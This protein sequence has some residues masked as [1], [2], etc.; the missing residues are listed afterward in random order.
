MNTMFRLN[1]YK[2]HSNYTNSPSCYTTQYSCSNYNNSPSYY[3]SKC[4]CTEVILYGLVASKLLNKT[5]GS[6]E[7][8][9]AWARCHDNL[10]PSF[11][12][13][14]TTITIPFFDCERHCTL[15]TKHKRTRTSG[16]VVVSYT[17]DMSN[18]T[19]VLMILGLKNVIKLT[20][21]F[22]F[23]YFLSWSW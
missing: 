10:Q 3:A 14:T 4:S 22:L 11:S 16:T 2:Y 19:C 12:F 9:A 18:T 21:N 7:P 1:L 13:I 17:Q 15:V 6:F 8:R 5:K 20:C 23:I